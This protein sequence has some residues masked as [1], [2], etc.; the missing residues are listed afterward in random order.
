[1]SIFDVL[2]NGSLGS[3]L[4]TFGRQAGAAASDF[5]RKAP[6]G[7]GGLLGAGALGALLGN[8]A[9]SDMLKNAGLIGAGAVAWN[10]YKKWAQSQAGKEAQQAQ[11]QAQTYSHGQIPLPG[12]PAVMHLDPTAE[13]VMRSMVYAAKADGNIDAAEQRRIDAILQN[14]MGGQDV[15]A[16]LKSMEAETLDPAKIAA[17]STSP[18]QADDIYRLSCSVIDIDHFMERGYLDALAKN[19]GISQSQQQ[20]IEAEASQARK[21]LAQHLGA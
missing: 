20:E 8:I 9:S 14:M 13:L 7:M 1:M 17:A 11:P 19:L 16:I 4:E 2:G 21:Q 18:E 5:K 15:S 6:G 3:V 10:F 12:K